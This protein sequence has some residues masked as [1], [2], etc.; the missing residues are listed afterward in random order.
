MPP[1]IL[2][3]NPKH[4]LDIAKWCIFNYITEAHLGAMS[5]MLG[6]SMDWFLHDREVS[7]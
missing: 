2:F 3:R 6:K 4:L 7:R 1:K 5:N